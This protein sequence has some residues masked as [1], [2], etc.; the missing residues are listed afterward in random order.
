MPSSASSSLLE[1]AIGAQGLRELRP[2][3]DTAKILD[4][5]SKRNLRLRTIAS[6]RV[7][8]SQRAVCCT[9][10]QEIATTVGAEALDDLVGGRSNR[11]GD[12]SLRKSLISVYFLSFR[13]H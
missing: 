10:L 13:M 1:S 3:L 5:S 9:L 8:L 7:H 11:W 4:T 6:H 2:R 12:Q